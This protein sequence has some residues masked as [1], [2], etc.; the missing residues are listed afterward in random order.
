MQGFFLVLEGPEGAGK[1]TLAATLSARAR[2]AGAQVVAVREPGGTTAA[3][4]ARA[5]VLDHAHAVGPEAELLLMLAARADLVRRVIGPALEAGSLVIADRFDLST[6][7]YQVAGRGLPADL[8][9]A[10]NRL[11]T[12]GLVPHLTLVL[13]VPPGTGRTRQ[14]AAGKTQDRLEAEDM[15]FHARVA[16][17]YLAAAGP[18]VRHLNAELPADR[19]A[20][21]AWAELEQRWRQT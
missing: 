15:D 20:E 7:A 16:A 3:E 13:D 2:A 5:I 1:S 17:A 8:V 18:G 21:A 11:A 10:A 12:G 14:A 4:A 9:A 19:L 6:Q